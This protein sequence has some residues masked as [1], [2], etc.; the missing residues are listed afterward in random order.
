[1]PSAFVLNL[2]V[3][4][5]KMRL[6]C[7]ET[8]AGHVGTLNARVEIS[9]VVGETLSALEEN[10]VSCC[11]GIRWEVRM[12]GAYDIAEKINKKNCYK[13]GLH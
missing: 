3:F 7:V 6:F 10:D 11:Y 1:M 12:V 4:F 5:Q 13:D 2:N 8:W 9:Q